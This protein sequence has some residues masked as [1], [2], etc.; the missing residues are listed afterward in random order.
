MNANRKKMWMILSLFAIAALL[1]AGVGAVKAA[2]VILAPLVGID[3][4]VANGGVDAGNCQNSGSPCA[5]I[6]YAIGQAVNG[7]T[8][9]VA[10]GTYNPSVNLNKSVTL[11]GAQAGVDARNGRPGASETIIAKGG[12]GTF[13][14][15]ATDVTFD[16]FTFTD[17]KGRTIDTYFDAHNFTMRNCILQS[18]SI[19]PGYNTG[20]IQ[21]GGGSS[22]QANG[23]LFEQNLVTADNGQLFYMGHSMDNGT[24][25]NNKFNGDSVAFGPF[26]TRSGWLIEGNEFDGNVSGHGPYWGFGFNANLGDVIIRNNVVRQMSVGFGQIS[27]VNGSITGNTFD[28]NAYAAFQL[29]GGEWGSVVSSNVMIENNL[30]KYNGIAYDNVSTY[31]AHGV[32]LR[33]GEGSV[34]PIDASTIHFHKNYF[35]NLGVGAAGSVWAIRQ[36]GSGIADA[37]NN[38]WGT[39][40]SLV[41]AA[42]IGEGSADY[43]PWISAYVND[44]S[45][46]GQPGFWPLPL[47]STDCYVDSASG[48]DA[49]DGSLA[50]PFKTI[51]KGITTVS[52]GGSVHV[53]AGTYPENVTVNK[54]L[55]LTGAGSTTGGTVIS[56]AGSGMGVYITASGPDSANPV[57]ISGV[58]VTN[59][60]NGLQTAGV[61]HVAFNDV[62]STA[63]INN[64]LELGNGTTDLNLSMCEFSHNTANGI[65]FGTAATVS[66]FSMDGCHVDYNNMGLVNFQTGDGS[67]N[68][69]NVVIKN[70][71]FNEN[72]QKGIYVEK[73]HNASFQNVVV[74][75]SG[76]DTAYVWSA[77]VD[78]NLKYRTDYANISF[79]NATITNNGVGA[80]NGVGLTIK[81]RDDAPSYNSKPASLTNVT[82]SNSLV[83]GN[84]VGIRFGEPAK[85]NSGPTNVTVGNVCF[86]NNITAGLLNETLTATTAESNW[87]GD[88][89]GPYNATKNAG[90]L[91]DPVS[92]NVDF[93]PWTNDGCHGTVATG[94]WKNLRTNTFN[95]LDDSMNGAASG[96][97]IQAVCTGATPVPGGGTATISG[98]SIDLHGCTVGPG[99]PFLIVTADDV[100]V[101][102]P[103]V[104]NGS[105]SADP[106]V[107]VNGGADNFMLQNVQVTGW[108]NAVK[109]AGSVDSFK[110]ISNWI[111]SN[112]SHGLL[113]DSGAAIGGVVTIQGNLFKVNGGNGV[114]ND[115]S[116]ANLKVEYNSWGSVSGPASPAG[117]GIGGSLDADP[118]TFAEVY[119]DMDPATAG[120]QFQ[121]NVYETQTF[122]VSL[123]VE[124][125]NLYGV[126]FTF[127]YDPAMLTPVGS[128]LFEA[129][130]AGKCVQPPGSLPAGTIS[131]VCNL[132]GGSAWNGGK[133]VTFS[134]TAGA[135]ATPL[136]GPWQTLFNV[137]PAEADTSAGAVG[138]VKVF[139]NNAGFNAPSSVDRDITDA[140]DGQIDITG[141]ARFKGYIDLQGRGND[142]GAVIKVYNDPNGVTVFAQ[143][144]SASSGAFLTAYQGSNVL[145]VGTTYYFSVDRDL[146]LPTAFAAGPWNPNKI[147]TTRPETSLNTL[148][149]LGG[150]A[151]N[152]NLIDP[153]DAAC[154]GSAYGGTL[155]TC[156]GTGASSD[157]NGDGI[158]NLYDLVLMGGNYFLTYSTWVP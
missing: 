94:H 37:E 100:S 57:T 150:D 155:N 101:L 51:T 40:D 14:L 109:V 69:D 8:I 77:G 107:L 124:A 60:S 130:W 96:D 129:P 61:S 102:G 65:R 12:L 45:K 141:V 70:S 118:F 92:G 116:T 28:D 35:Q 64:G 120:D 41:I 58:R 1:F 148:L 105:G 112:S 53:A 79:V 68:F 104:L 152:D 135:G 3:L 90:G 138:G 85:G 140:N 139:V 74:N 106:A 27:V 4:Y 66:G 76:W 19:D 9:N 145:Q 56:G 22:L 33:P 86:D 89:T 151:T 11:K 114:Q 117:D 39:T 115:G 147:L 44:P 156:S 2:G 29:W 52:V 84:Q 91:G 82:I 127:A 113:V 131:Y 73:L 110:M 72:K 30:I 7:D 154:I 83:D 149:L 153:G 21:F 133:L 47:C 26:G 16:G 122:N 71:T 125:A 134:F 62:V 80:A 24:F 59:F 103:G 111:H 87:W 32:R 136:N 128:P 49:N 75:H 95:D 157:V 146:F 20:G 18:P 6:E 43:D 137:S 158:V 63:N 55:L 123:N 15:N 121:R 97:T 5:T 54:Y 132:T 23:L 34:G 50:Y 42:M 142:S 98:V 17:I 126:S 46:A 93:E 36:Q 48:N 99:S 13:L 10:A 143:G 144:S 78:I 67:S 31:P 38:W 108:A 81:A 119:L 88:A 25:R